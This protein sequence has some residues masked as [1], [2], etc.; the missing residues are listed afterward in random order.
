LGGPPVVWHADV[1]ASQ[2]AELDPL[3][4]LPAN[5]KQAR[6]RAVCETGGTPSNDAARR[7]LSP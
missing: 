2:P 5:E 7:E 1:P 4:E 6:E 3:P